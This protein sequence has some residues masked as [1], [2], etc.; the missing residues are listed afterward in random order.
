MQTC[1][2]STF[3]LNC[4]DWG[5]SLKGLMVSYGILAISEYNLESSHL[6]IPD[7]N[8]AKIVKIC[9]FWTFYSVI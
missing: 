3:E 9:N 2:G 8:E 7:T 6:R 4:R 5:S 1:M